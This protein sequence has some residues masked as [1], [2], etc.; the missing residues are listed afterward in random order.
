MLDNY[1]DATHS[2]H[3]VQSEDSYSEECSE[4]ELDPDCQFMVKCYSCTGVKFKN[5]DKCKDKKWIPNT[6]PLA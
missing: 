2:I 1:C 6:H 3:F 4:P 5:C